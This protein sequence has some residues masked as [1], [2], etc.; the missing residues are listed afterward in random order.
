[1]LSAAHTSLRHC[2]SSPSDSSPSHMFFFCSKK[3]DEVEPVDTDQAR[4]GTDNSY[5]MK[6]IG[7]IT[8]PLY[9]TQRKHSEIQG[10]TEGVIGEDHRL[11]GNL[12]P[13]NDRA[14]EKEQ[15]HS[16]C[17]NPCCSKGTPSFLPSQ[18]PAF[19]FFAPCKQEVISTHKNR[20]TKTLVEIGRYTTTDMLEMS[21]RAEPQHSEHLVRESD[22]S[23]AERWS[24]GNDFMEERQP[25]ETARSAFWC[26]GR[27]ECGNS[28]IIM[29]PLSCSKGHWAEELRNPLHAY[30]YIILG[31]ITLDK[32]HSY[33]SSA[34]F[35]P[36]TYIPALP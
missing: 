31:W 8:K 13:P 14:V 5:S 12:L 28:S 34:S 10:G 33:I 3:G 27:N 25:E 6:H 35:S 1:M 7:R 15:L 26:S 18:K 23:Q 36:H 21:S 17:G 30:T 29:Q 24:Q 2:L 32:V 22:K 11:T 20:N 9:F 4:G 16:A 19:F